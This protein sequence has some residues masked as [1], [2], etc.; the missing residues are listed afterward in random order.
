MKNSTQGK[1]QK[2]LVSNKINL[3]GYITLQ[4]CCKIYK[5]KNKKIDLFYKFMSKHHNELLY[6][7]NYK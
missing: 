4:V 6:W 5:E 3:L 1:Y 7:N 2:K